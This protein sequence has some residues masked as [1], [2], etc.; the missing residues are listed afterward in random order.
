MFGGA[1][2][3]PHTSAGD[4][5]R[6]QAEGQLQPGLLAGHALPGG[7]TTRLPGGRLPLGQAQ[8]IFQG[9]KIFQFYRE[10]ISGSGGDK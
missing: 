1:A 10:N 7:R 8:K 4:G 3:Q 9:M 6:P 2:L 5:E